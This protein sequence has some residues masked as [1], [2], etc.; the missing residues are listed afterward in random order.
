M[1]F[2]KGDVLEDVL[3]AVIDMDPISEI[4][5]LFFAVVDPGEWK[6][7]DFGEA[8]REV[9]D[10]Y[11]KGYIQKG[12]GNDVMMHLGKSLQG[13]SITEKDLTYILSRNTR[14]QTDD[15]DRDNVFTFLNIELPLAIGRLGGNA[16]RAAESIGSAYRDDPS[17]FIR[18][19]KASQF[20]TYMTACD[21]IF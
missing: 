2:K 7:V 21:G 3:N 18:A 15:F 14:Y 10:R 16:S 8:A 17:R 19:N 1:S 6:N 20:C 13:E 12:T 11:R 9:L 5:A 4:R